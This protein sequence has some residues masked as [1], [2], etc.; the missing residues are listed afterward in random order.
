MVVVVV[1]EVGKYCNENGED[2]DE[3]IELEGKD[4]HVEEGEDNEKM[5]DEDYYGEARVGEKADEGCGQTSPSSTHS[6]RTQPS[7]GWPGAA[8]PRGG[9]RLLCGLSLG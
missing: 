3:K 6:T 4:C 9:C 8:K 7:T 1:E 2:N 5:E